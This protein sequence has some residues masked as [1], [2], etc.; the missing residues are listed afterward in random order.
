MKLN[1]VHYKGKLY[2]NFNCGNHLRFGKSYCFSHFIQ[3]KDIEAIVLDDIRGM[4]QRIVLDEKTIYGTMPNLQ[5][6]R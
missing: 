6:K 1:Y 2:F 3:A 5:I 4:A